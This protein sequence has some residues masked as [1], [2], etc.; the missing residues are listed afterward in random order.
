MRSRLLYRLKAAFRRIPGPWRP[1][2]DLL[3]GE[4]LRAEL[5]P[6]PLSFLDLHT[7]FI[8]LLGVGIGF[9]YLF[10]A[11]TGWVSFEDFL[12]YSAGVTAIRFLIWALA[13]TVF[14]IGA[15][16]ILIRWTYLAVFGAFIAFALYLT[17]QA[18]DIGANAFFL[19][20]YS[21]V[22]AVLGMGLVDLYRRSHTYL[23][24]DLRLI[25]KAGI[26]RKRERTV[27]YENV[28]DLTTTQGVLGRIF[29]YGTIIP[30]TASGI[31]TG[32]DEA[33]AGGGVGGTTEEGQV[34]GGL[35]AGGSRKVRVARA[36]SHAQ[37]TGVHPFRTVRV[38]VAQLL[39]ESS[40]VHYAK[41]QRDLLAEMRDIMASQEEPDY[42]YAY[43][44]P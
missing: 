10:N 7:P 14:A 40:M 38:L 23:V 22:M 41:E 11:V 44:Q 43:D 26:I 28:T 8:Y 2:Y 37:L 21:T 39:Q 32:A 35:F 27:R 33:F 34:G 20:V 3:R 4:D 19:P 6:H 42:Y 24:T 16:V 30:V 17:I 13:L 29:G 25:L 9:A 5:T 1:R 31:G 15:S 12:G 18:P 36:R